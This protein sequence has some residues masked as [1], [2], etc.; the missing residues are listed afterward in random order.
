MSH[1]SPQNSV[2]YRSLIDQVELPD[3]T[4]QEVGLVGLLTTL[5]IL[6]DEPLGMA[7]GQLAQIGFLYTWSFPI[8][9]CFLF[10]SAM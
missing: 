5:P 3:K 7:I 8:G 10:G 6:V 2:D 4:N 9:A 1:F